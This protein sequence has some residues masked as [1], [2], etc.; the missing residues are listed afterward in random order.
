MREMAQADHERIVAAVRARDG[1]AARAAMREHLEH[2]ASTLAEE[3][4]AAEESVARIEPSKD[5]AGPN[6]REDGGAA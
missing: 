1:A 5:V 3:S 4:L 2:V 6:R